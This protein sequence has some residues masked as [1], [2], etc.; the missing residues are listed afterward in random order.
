MSDNFVL[1]IDSKL[2]Y[3]LKETRILK[4]I[5]FYDEKVFATYLH[6][7]LCR[8]FFLNNLCFWNKEEETI[9]YWESLEHKDFLDRAK[10]LISLLASMGI[11][12]KKK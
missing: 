10:G 5:P 9:N 2:L 12:Y 8:D 6:K 1:V 11:Y 3:S 7:N 4:D